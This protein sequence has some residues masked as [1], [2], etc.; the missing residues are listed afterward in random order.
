MNA[1][2]QKPFAWSYSKLKNFETCPKRHYEIDLAKN[3]QEEESDTLKWG[4][5]V[6]KHLA[7]RCGWKRVPL[8]ETMKPFEKWCE[9]V[10]AGAGDIEVEQKLAI[11]R[12]YGPCGYFDRTAWFRGIGDVIK[13]CEDVA[14]ILDWKT[15]KV[16]DDSVQLALMAQCVFAHYPDIKKV[17]SEF[18]WL[19]YEDTSTGETFSR[20]DM[21]NLWKYIW[22][23]VESLENAYKTTTYPAKPGSL[24]KK[25]CPVTSC[26]HHGK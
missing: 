21:P 18:I 11:T 25:W 16:L 23:R 3:F 20:E 12:D 1:P 7:A 8:P 13:R 26:P 15:G 24:C 2:Y 17:R 9:R 22:H 5:E 10:T 14:L 19:K 4:N 6:H